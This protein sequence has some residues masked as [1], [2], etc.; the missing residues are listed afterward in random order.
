MLKRNCSDQGPLPRQK[1][2]VPQ[3]CISNVNLNS[4]LRLPP[5]PSGVIPSSNDHSSCSQRSS[6]TSPLTSPIGTFWIQYGLACSLSSL[7]SRPTP[8][9]SSLSSKVG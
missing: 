9:S 5:C 4:T 1:G 7:A 6:R 8:T 3:P 2:Y